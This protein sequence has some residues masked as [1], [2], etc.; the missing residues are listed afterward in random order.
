MRPR[1]ASRRLWPWRW[2]RSAGHDAALLE[3]KLLPTTDSAMF[4]VR[5]VAH[6]G[7]A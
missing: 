7:G 1:N 4:E 6:A 5:K 3:L 2:I